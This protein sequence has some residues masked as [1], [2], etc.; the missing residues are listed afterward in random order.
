LEDLQD[1]ETLSKRKKVSSGELSSMVFA[2]RTAQAFMSDDGKASKLAATIIP[3]DHIQ[4]T[5]HLIGWLYFEG[6]LQDSDKD[7][8]VAELKQFDRNLQPHLDKAY[9]EALRCRLMNSN[10]A[11]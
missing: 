5:T 9:E 1:I 4:S 10:P 3:G 7:K 2:K 11:K 6:K 8:I